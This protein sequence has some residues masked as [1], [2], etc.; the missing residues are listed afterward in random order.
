VNFVL[1]SFQRTGQCAGLHTQEFKAVVQMRRKIKVMV[2]LA[3]QI[4]VLVRTLRLIEQHTG[5]TSLSCYTKFGRVKT[6]KHPNFCLLFY[7]LFLALAR[8]NS[9][10]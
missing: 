9:V 2:A 8:E 4:I 7:T 6:P 3:V 5:G 1:L 10:K